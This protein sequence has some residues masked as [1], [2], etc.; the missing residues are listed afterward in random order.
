MEL[1]IYNVHHNRKVWGDDCDAYNPDRF[2]PENVDGMDSYAFVPF[3]AGPRN[4]IGQVFAMNEMKTTIATILRKFDFSLDET[5]EARMKP[6]LV[7]HAENG[8][9]LFFQERCH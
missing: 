6:D 9:K 7:L 4:C 2:L 8:I 5:H 1:N 3:S